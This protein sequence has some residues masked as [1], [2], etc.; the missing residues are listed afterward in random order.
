M[1]MAHGSPVQN[2]GNSCSRYLFVAGVHGGTALLGTINRAEIQERQ[3]FST[4]NALLGTM[5][6]GTY[7]W[8]ILLKHRDHKAAISVPQNRQ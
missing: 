8:R 3:S 4:G 6:L 5:N 1:Y 2:G 7:R